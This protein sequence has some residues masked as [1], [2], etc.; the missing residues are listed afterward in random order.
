MMLKKKVIIT[1]KIIKDLGFIFY[2]GNRIVSVYFRNDHISLYLYPKVV[3]LYNRALTKIF[4][5]EEI[6]SFIKYLKY[7]DS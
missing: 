5:I 3:V 2:T 4:K 7:C 1:D 6:N